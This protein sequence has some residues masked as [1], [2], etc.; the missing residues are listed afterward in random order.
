MNGIK[1]YIQMVE[2]LVH[3]G[4]PVNMPLL[5]YNLAEDYLE[6]LQG[7]RLQVIDVAVDGSGY[8]ALGEGKKSGTFIWMIDKKDT[9]G[10]M[11]LAAPDPLDIL[12]S[13]MK[14]VEK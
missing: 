11:E 14:G 9:I 13:L 12:M 7:K 8:L 4:M 10:E 5:G 6:A 1:G 2:K 3:T